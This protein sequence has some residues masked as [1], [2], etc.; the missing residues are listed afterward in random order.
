MHHH[1]LN[2]GTPGERPSQLRHTPDLP[3]FSP[4]QDAVIECANKQASHL[5]AHGAKLH[6]LFANPLLVRVSEN[7]K[8]P[9]V[10]ITG[11]WLARGAFLAAIPLSADK[12]AP[13]LFAISRVLSV[14]PH[15]SP[16]GTIEPI[17][18][19]TDPNC[20]AR[21]LIPSTSTIAAATNAAAQEAA[22]HL[23]RVFPQ[24]IDLAPR[25]L[26]A[27]DDRMVLAHALMLHGEP[28]ALEIALGLRTLAQIAPD[29][30]RQSIGLEDEIRTSVRS[31][32]MRK[33][34]SI[35]R[36]TRLHVAHFKHECYGDEG[37]IGSLVASLA[38]LAEA[39]A[40]ATIVASLNHYPFSAPQLGAL[41]EILRD[42][43][44]QLM[45]K[46]PLFKELWVNLPKSE[47]GRIARDA[48]KQAWSA[49][50]RRYA[51][52]N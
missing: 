51:M 19:E 41:K 2:P 28:L 21:F 26:I 48:A 1:H 29:S 12:V 27:H 20:A 35:F 43:L 31:S 22:A 24:R 38:E 47:R 42:G 15:L 7:P 44:K 3:R 40:K 32:L 18:W 25:G 14:N 4:L 5:A 23:L 16:T 13:E 36:E 17:P 9:E 33:T 11:R 37:P 8:V 34:L 45:Q 30:I 39:R 46:E 49:C 50:V 6:E 10:A 52:D